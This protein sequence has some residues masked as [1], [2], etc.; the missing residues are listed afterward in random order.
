VTTTSVTRT[1]TGIFAPRDVAAG[2]DAATPGV[3][4]RRSGRRPEGPRQLQR[5]VS[6]PSL[7]QRSEE[8]RALIDT[9]GEPD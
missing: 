3:A 1:G 4:R 9:R 6:R 2:V 8:L 7:C 5:K